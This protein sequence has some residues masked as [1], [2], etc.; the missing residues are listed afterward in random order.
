MRE[1]YWNNLIDLRFKAYYYECYAG[2]VS[3]VDTALAIVIALVTS[4]SVGTWLRNRDQAEA[5]AAV[6]LIAQA[7]AVVRPLVPSIKKS[8]EYTKC[9]LA[10]E[11][12]YVAM[13]TVWFQCEAAEND[14]GY[15]PALAELREKLL[16]ID[17]HHASLPMWDVWFVKRKA[18]SKIDDFMRLN[19]PSS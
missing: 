9:A 1:R 12:L 14:D 7:L 18:R 19:F 11:K 17:C 13:E 10:H 4:A 3:V 16:K 5:C 8:A 2:F 15:G 6:I